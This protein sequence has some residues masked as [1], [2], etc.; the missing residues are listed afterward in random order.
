[1]T[2]TVEKLK[3]AEKERDL[4]LA[5]IKSVKNLNAEKVNFLEKKL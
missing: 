2:S 1:M 5:E 3:M 4:A